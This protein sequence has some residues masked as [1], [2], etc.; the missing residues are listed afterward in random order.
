MAHATPPALFQ[1]W[2]SAHF[3]RPLS[4]TAFYL[5]LVGSVIAWVIF[6]FVLQSLPSFAR[7]RLLVVTTFIAGL[8]FMLEFFLPAKNNPLTGYVEP[9]GTFLQVVGGFGLGIG[10]ISLCQVHGRAILRRQ[11]GYL[12]SIAFFL[13]FVLMI[14]AAFWQH[15]VKEGTPMETVAKRFYSFMFDGLYVALDST[16]FSLLAFFIVSAA[17][18]AFRIRSAEASLMM[19]AAFIVMLGQV[20]IGMALTHWLPAEGPLGALRLERLTNWILTGMNA[21]AF[22]AILFGSTVGY[23][24][25]SLRVWLS[26]ERGSYFEKPL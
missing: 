6:L 2:L 25:M 23:I 13:A 7:R 14:A 19:I 11:P 12:N 24:A 5:A 17:Y 26:L 3:F 8:F 1:R 16:V 22:R 20:P 18:R 4:G 21:A 15:Y 10:V 9:L